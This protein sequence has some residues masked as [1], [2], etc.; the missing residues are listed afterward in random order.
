MKGRR[1]HDPT[2]WCMSSSLVFLVIVASLHLLQP[3]YDPLHQFMSELA[4]GPYGGAMFFAFSALAF[5]T[6]SLGVLCLRR[7]ALRLASI[8]LFGAAASFLGAGVFRLDSTSELHIK[9]IALAFIGSSLAMYLLPRLSGK[10]H[11]LS[12]G[13]GAGMAL[14]VTLPISTPGLT[15]RL[16]AVCLLLWVVLASRLHK[17]QA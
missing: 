3:G 14:F 12:W 5:S 15:Q 9:L 4:L 1:L 7:R 11:L 16:A 13:L 8:P 10:G 6:G 17:S 2:F